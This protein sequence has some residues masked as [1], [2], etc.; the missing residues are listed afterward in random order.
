M[1]SDEL[2]FSDLA[3]EVS[4]GLGLSPELERSFSL[5]LSFT[6]S[7]WY[8]RGLEWTPGNVVP[9]GETAVAVTFD[10]EDGGNLGMGGR[11]EM[12][13]LEAGPLMTPGFKPDG[14]FESEGLALGEEEEED[15]ERLPSFILAL[16][17]VSFNPV[18]GL[19]VNSSFLS[20]V[21][22][23]SPAPVLDES[24]SSFSFFSIIVT[25]SAV[26]PTPALSLSTMSDKLDP[27]RFLGGD[28][29]ALSTGNDGA[30]SSIDVDDV[31]DCEFARK[32]VANEEDEDDSPVDTFVIV[33]ASLKLLFNFSVPL[34]DELDDTFG[35]ERE[36]EELEDDEEDME[37]E[38]EEELEGRG[39]EG[40][41]LELLS[42]SLLLLSLGE[43]DG[44][45]KVG[46]A[47]FS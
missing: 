23:P 4:L 42:L 5:S 24:L 20:P 46:E 28:A 21:F 45:E 14:D 41:E 33:R 31:L 39:R 3:G 25:A 29:L 22:L 9:S 19:T 26:P 8:C 11:L 15:L 44:L 12:D 2:L 36:E 18:E 6:R 16:L 1:P 47:D 7:L 38:E 30:F 35:L 10:T 13:F 17:I 32:D 37:E 27:F 43:R 40:L 34:E